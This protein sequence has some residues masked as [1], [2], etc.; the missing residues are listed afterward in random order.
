MRSGFVRSFLMNSCND[1]LTRDTAMTKFY[2]ILDLAPDQSRNRIVEIW[3][4]AADSGLVNPSF[5]WDP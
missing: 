2:H 5:L 3:A 4:R 1:W